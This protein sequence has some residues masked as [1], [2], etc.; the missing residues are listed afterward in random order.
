MF[1]EIV[2]GIAKNTSILLL[3]HVLTISIR[4]GEPLFLSRFRTRIPIPLVIEH[5]E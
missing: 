3:Q 5:I 4:V 1:R 2:K